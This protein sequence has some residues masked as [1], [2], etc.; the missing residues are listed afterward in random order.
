MQIFPLRQWWNIRLIR[1]S[2]NLDLC[3]TPI[4]TIEETGLICHLEGPW[5]GDG[6]AITQRGIQCVSGVDNGEI[7]R[8]YRTMADNQE[9]PRQETQ[10]T[11]SLITYC[12]R[13]HS[14]NCRFIALGAIFLRILQ[15]GKCSRCRQ[16]WI[17][18]ATEAAPD[19]W[20]AVVMCKNRTLIPFTL[21]RPPTD[22]NKAH[23]KWVSQETPYAAWVCYFLFMGRGRW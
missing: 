10:R 8:Q 18:S 14:F 17:I 11:R 15:Q 7:K 4:G 5:A 23:L 3:N 2:N 19:G 21:S 6:S 1:W 16:R 20:Q 12:L 22:S 9:H 13:V